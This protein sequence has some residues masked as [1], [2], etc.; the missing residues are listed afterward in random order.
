MSAPRFEPD[1][2]HTLDAAWNRRPRRLPL[3][4]HLVNPD[5]MENI[6]QRKFVGLLAGNDAD[7]REF[8]RIHNGFFRDMT[9][10]TVSYEVCITDVLPG[11][12]ALL[13]PSQGSAIKSRADFDAYPW[14]DLPRIYWAH[15]AP[16]F[17]AMAAEMPP[18]MK[19][20]GGI[21]NGVFE[22]SEDLVGYE[23]LCLMLADDPELFAELYGRIGDLIV[24]LW[25]TFLPRFGDAYAVCRMGDDLGFKSSTLLAPATL[26][27]HVIPQ[28]RRI[29]RL[30]HE[31]G[32]PWL[33]HSCGKIFPVMDA[34]IGAG[35]NAKH[36]NEDAVAK[37]DEWIERY[38][39]RIG[40]FGG[41]D[42]DRLCRMTPPDL[43]AF[44]IE[45]GT[46]FRAKARGYA[47]GSG[48]SIPAYV[49]RE[50]YL[51][52]VEAVQEIRRREGG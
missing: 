20:V 33:Q 19:A 8:F 36:S 38:G 45:E 14:A 3:Y 37:Y 44:V 17:E 27:E 24:G 15:A 32:K 10:D 30:I 18:G 4:E 13:H 41:I 43:R 7:R 5:S 49:P 23:N 50:G 48:N 21:G 6:L 29:V 39:D 47:L 1:Y 12:G 51:A 16:R 25:T 2:R 52:M 40:L 34:W 35:I 42:T 26:I 11:G 28:Y 9:Y 46:R 22:V 31:A